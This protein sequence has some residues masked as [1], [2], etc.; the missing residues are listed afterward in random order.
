MK[1]WQRNGFLIPLCG[2]GAGLVNGLVGA[3]GGV[4]CVFALSYL[5]RDRVEDR[6]DIFANTIA[7]MLPLSAVSSLLY[8]V[9]GS[10]SLTGFSPYLLPALLGG[11]GGALLLR[12]LRVSVVQKLF[13]IL[14][15]YSGITMVL[16]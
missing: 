7:I 4:I 11:A 12:V 10:M 15:L 5:L 8:I 14:V 1:V 9:G 6:K 13:A 3:G 2:L 16:R